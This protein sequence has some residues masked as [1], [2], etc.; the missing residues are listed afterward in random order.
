MST[1][2]CTLEILRGGTGPPGRK[3]PHTSSQHS[4]GKKATSSIQKAP[5]PFPSATSKKQAVCV[6]AKQDPR[7][8][9]ARF[10]SYPPSSQRC[11]H[12]QDTPLLWIWKTKTD[13]SAHLRAAGR[14]SERLPAPRVLTG[15]VSSVPTTA[16]DA[17]EGFPRRVRHGHPACS[18]F[19]DLHREPWVW[20]QGP[21]GPLLHRE[22]TWVFLSELL[23]FARREC[24]VT[25]Q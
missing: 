6:A 20:T 21:G 7:T 4:A 19:L 23:C 1:R 10:V 14:V 9:S 2:D 12:E 5:L 22:D 15:H 24:K 18:C 17:G 13:V 8:R 25:P 11:E 16:L 3:E